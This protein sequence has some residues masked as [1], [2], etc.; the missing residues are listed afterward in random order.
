MG[1]NSAREGNSV[2]SEHKSVTS[3]VHESQTPKA[4]GHIRLSM[5]PKL[6]VVASRGCYWLQRSQECAS[7]GVNLALVKTNAFSQ[8]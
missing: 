8:G 2:V 1:E 7:P 4:R 3:E 6:A 5:R